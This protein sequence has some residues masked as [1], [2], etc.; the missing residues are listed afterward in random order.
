MRLRRPVPPFLTVCCSTAQ[1]CVCVCVCV[2]V[3]RARVRVLTRFTS[4]PCAQTPTHSMST[5]QSSV[6]RRAHTLTHSSPVS[7]CCYTSCQP[8]YPI[9][10]RTPRSTRM[11]ATLPQFILASSKCVS[12]FNCFWACCFASHENEMFRRISPVSAKKIEVRD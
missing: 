10:S 8:C 5:L 6:S 3:C 4:L 12:A 9:A 11:F 2:C 7:L 1:L